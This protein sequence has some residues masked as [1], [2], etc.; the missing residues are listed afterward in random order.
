LESEHVDP[1]SYVL[2]GG[3]TDER[4]VVEDRRSEWVVYY[5]ERGLERSLSGYPTEAEALDDLLD[6]LLRD[7]TTR[8]RT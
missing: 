5:S 6:R 3:Y 7:S 2:D 1:R 8:R 4:Y